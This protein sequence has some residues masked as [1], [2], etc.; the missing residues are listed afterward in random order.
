MDPASRLRGL[1]GQSY[2]SQA[3]VAWGLSKVFLF[4]SRIQGAKTTVEDTGR[5]RL[6][7]FSAYGRTSCEAQPD[8]QSE[9]T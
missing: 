4:L 6:M 5:K 3:S 2:G 8:S 1:P 9:R 7:V